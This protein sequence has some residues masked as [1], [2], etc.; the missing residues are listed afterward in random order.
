MTDDVGDFSHV[1]GLSYFEE[2]ATD[3][4]VNRLPSIQNNGATA[5][6]VT[7]NNQIKADSTSVAA[8]AQGSW[9]PSVLEQKLE[10]TTGIRWT[11]DEREF[12]QTQPVA[13]TAEI[14][15]NN[16]SYTVSTSY[17]WTP[18]I[19]TSARYSTGYRAGGYN[20]RAPAA[21]TDP[22]FEPEKLKAVEVGFKIDALDRRLRVNGTAYH[23]K[24]DDLQ[25][26][27]FAP[28]AAVLRSTAMPPSRALNSRFRLC[29]LS[30]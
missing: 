8:F 1:E 12:D 18:D 11:K 16:T 29:H 14:N 15:T 21:V 7:V 6:D 19:M 20:S 23:S 10:V 30:G 24:Y 2:R 9:R 13:R 25:I 28:P 17:K 22:V 26:F 4:R 3:R 5:V 27:S